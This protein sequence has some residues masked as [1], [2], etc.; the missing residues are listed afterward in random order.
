MGRHLLPTPVLTGS[1]LGFTV[2]V[3]Q[4]GF[5]AESTPGLHRQYRALTLVANKIDDQAPWRP[6]AA[7]SGC[8][9][10][11][12]Q[13]NGVNEEPGYAAGVVQAELRSGGLRKRLR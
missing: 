13:L 7:W 1:G 5:A 2:S 11:R 12:A 10:R 3:S 9:G 4:A 8:D 6:G